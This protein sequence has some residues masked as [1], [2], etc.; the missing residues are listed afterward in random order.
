MRVC[1]YVRR[2]IHTK[3]IQL[4]LEHKHIGDTLRSTLTCGLSRAHS[5]E[6]STHI[7]YVCGK[8]NNTATAKP[9]GID[10]KRWADRHIV[11]VREGEHERT[12][13]SVLLLCIGFACVLS[14]CLPKTHRRTSCPWNIHHFDENRICDSIQSHCW[15][16]SIVFNS[17]EGYWAYTFAHCSN[18]Y[19]EFR[20]SPVCLCAKIIIITSCVCVHARVCV[21]DWFALLNEL[22]WFKNHRYRYKTKQKLTWERKARKKIQKKTQIL[23]RASVTA[24]QLRW[25]SN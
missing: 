12:N 4:A 22:M 5:Y 20:F 7:C 10:R 23:N 9:N 6:L 21:S 19:T 16:R 11:R 13:E 2:T 1:L 15:R 3:R 17:Q 24:A 18:E 25:Y 14:F 8:N